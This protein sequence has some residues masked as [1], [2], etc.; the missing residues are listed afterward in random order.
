MLSKGGNEFFHLN[1][2]ILLASLELRGLLGIVREPLLKI[3]ILGPRHLELLTVHLQQL[4]M[5]VKLTVALLSLLKGQVKALLVAKLICLQLLRELVNDL[6]GLP[7]YQ[8]LREISLLQFLISLKKLLKLGIQLV[9]HKLILHEDKACVYLIPVAGGVFIGEVVDLG[10]T[11][12][13]EVLLIVV[14][15]NHIS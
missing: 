12:K 14:V 7:D 5:L 1:L 11:P 6:F 13:E 8:I 9:K 10:A 3:K 15:F 2:K 4:L